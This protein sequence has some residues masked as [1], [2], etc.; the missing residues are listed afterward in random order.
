MGFTA[1]A[2]L[3]VSEYGWWGAYLTTQ[4]VLGTRRRGAGYSLRTLSVSGVR[5][6]GA[7]Y[8]QHQP[9]DLRHQQIGG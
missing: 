9:V 6:Y 4:G 2:R 5:M 3:F 1:D 7:L 8:A